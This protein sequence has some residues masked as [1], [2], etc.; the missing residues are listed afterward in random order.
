MLFKRVYCCLGMICLFCWGKSLTVC[1]W[2]LQL[3]E[4]QIFCFLSSISLNGEDCV[5]PSTLS[6]HQGHLHR[7]AFTCSKWVLQLLFSIMQWMNGI[8]ESK[9]GNWRRGIFIIVVINLKKE[10]WWNRDI[11]WSVGSIDSNQN[12]RNSVFGNKSK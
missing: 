5:D 2:Y 11:L 10:K 1:Q 4:I 8:V 7:N 3:Q 9:Y 6:G 12:Q